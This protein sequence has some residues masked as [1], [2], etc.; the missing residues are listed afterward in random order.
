MRIARPHRTPNQP[1]CAEAHQ[2][3][4]VQAKRKVVSNVWNAVT[5]PAIDEKHP[6]AMR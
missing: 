4:K 1:G 5:E 6:I 3:M 2:E